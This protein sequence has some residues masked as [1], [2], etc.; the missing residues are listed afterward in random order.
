MVVEVPPKRELTPEKLHAVNTGYLKSAK[1]PAEK[2]HKREIAAEVA[3]DMERGIYRRANGQPWKGGYS[4]VEIAFSMGYTARKP[5]GKLPTFF[6]EPLFSR[7]VEWE[8]RKRDATFRVSMKEAM[9]ML[10]SVVGGFLMEAL[11]RVLLHP[12]TIPSHVLFPELRKYIEMK[13]E[14]EGAFNVRPD[15]Q[16]SIN[17]FYQNV[18]GLPEEA[19]AAALEMFK[20]EMASLMDAGR[21][22][23]AVIDVDIRGASK[24]LATT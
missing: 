2:E 18:N 23:Q 22:A 10:D 15:V 13:G 8:R 21:Q 19:R 9:P 7:A 1:T 3:V 16:Q 24:T 12:E 20:R 17:V 14:Y 4:K 11:R 5:N 6:K